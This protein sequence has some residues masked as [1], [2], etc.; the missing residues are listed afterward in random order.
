MNYSYQNLSNTSATFQWGPTFEESP[1]TFTLLGGVAGYSNFDSTKTSL[2]LSRQSTNDPIYITPILG[3]GLKLYPSNRVSMEAIG[4]LKLPSNF[5]QTY[6]YHYEIGTRIYINDLLNL[7]IGYS[8]FHLG[9]GNI[10]RMQIGL[11]F[12]F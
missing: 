12:T 6:L 7:K 2:T 8:Q 3:L 9:S 11:G 1:I 10:Q 5:D 4:S